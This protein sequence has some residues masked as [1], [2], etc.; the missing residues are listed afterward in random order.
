MNR[1][2][3]KESINVAGFEILKAGSLLKRE[4]EALLKVRRDLFDQTKVFLDLSNEMAEAL[5]IS[6]DE[7]WSIINQNG[8]TETGED[9]RVKILPFMIKLQERLNPEN[10]QAE[11]PERAVEIFLRSRLDSNWLKQVAPELGEAF[12][13]QVSKEQIAAIQK[14]SFVDY[15]DD[16][17]REQI[18]KQLVFLLPEAIFDEILDLLA[19][20]QNQWKELDP[21]EA[22]AEEEVIDKADPLPLES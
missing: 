18:I 11:Y 10:A 19:K 21:Q 4:R 15:L 8:I 2:L 7:A 6:Q 12:G 9:L 17:I 14:V 1:F 22:V 5:G 13:L 16:P 3:K 20:E